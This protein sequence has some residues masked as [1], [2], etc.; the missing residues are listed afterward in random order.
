MPIFNYVE[1]IANRHQIHGRSLILNVLK[2]NALQ[3][4]GTQWSIDR[5]SVGKTRLNRSFTEANSQVFP[6]W[7]N[8]M[9][10]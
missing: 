3:R 7:L 1:K 10:R 9:Q 8:V 2:N 6:F 4:S 5:N